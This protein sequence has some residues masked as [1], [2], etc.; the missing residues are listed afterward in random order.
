M[1]ITRKYSNPQGEKMFE[2][3]LIP[4]DG[5]EFA[6]A[7][8]P[9]GKEIS[10]AFGSELILLHVCTH[11]CRNYEHMHKI[12][13]NSLAETLVRNPTEGQPQSGNNNVTIKTEEGSPSETIGTFVGKNNIDLIIMTSDGATD[14]KIETLGS[15]ADHISRTVKIPVLLVK[16]RIAKPIENEK[17]LIKRILVT[18]DGSDLSKLALPIAEGLANKLQI[19]MTLF[20]MA[21]DIYPYYGEPAPFVDYEK[22]AAD[23][24]RKVRAE[25]SA[26]EEEFRNKGQIVA[27]EV[28]SGR[29]AAHEISEL[30]K[31]LGDCLLVMS[32][33]GRSGFGR[34]ALGSVAERA[35]RQVKVPVLLVPARTDRAH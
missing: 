21:R 35:L 1:I 12:Y 25:M 31:K 5:S 16:T 29:D 9:Y 15:V 28:T 6:E 8:L 10:R 4:L 17:P 20:Q 34:W 22:M 24:E 23:E 2:K 26:I 30:S 32:T 19:P 27:W 11:E 3:I 7:A 14:H 18:L 13:L 33:H